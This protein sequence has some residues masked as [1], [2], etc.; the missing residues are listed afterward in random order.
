MSFLRNIS[1][2]FDSLRSDF[3]AKSIDPNAGAMPNGNRMG[4][5]RIICE[6]LT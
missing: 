4:K 3:L 1:S 6:I 5:D 2:I